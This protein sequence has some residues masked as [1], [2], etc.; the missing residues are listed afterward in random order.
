[1][2]EKKLW[3]VFFLVLLLGGCDTATIING[4]VLGFRSGQFMY[5]EG[6]LSATYK[7]DIEKVWAACDRTVRELKGKEIVRER[8]ISQGKIKATIQDENVT[9]AVE[10]IARDLT[11]VSVLIGLG[12]NIA[13]RL[14]HEKI[15]GNLSRP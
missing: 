12:N 5:A 1:M 9:I 3:F 6:S 11:S 4:K 15:T 2:S 10:Y 8:G 14:I 13:S 7:A